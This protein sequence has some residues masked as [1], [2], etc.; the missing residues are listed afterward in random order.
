MSSVDDVPATFISAVITSRA[1]SIAPEPIPASA[2]GPA[3]M[4]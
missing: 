4:N 1:G 3:S 2:N